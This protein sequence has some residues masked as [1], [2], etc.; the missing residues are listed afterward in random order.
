MKIAFGMIVFNGAYVL[1]ECLESVYPFASQILVAEGPVGYWQT[2][3]HTTSTDGTNGILKSFPDPDN[4]ITVVHGQYSEKDEQCSA[5]MEHLNSD[6]DYVWNLDSDE[7]FKPEDIE[8]IIKLLTDHR[9]TTAGFQ[10]CSFY[11]GFDKI[12]GG[13]EENAEFRRVCKVYPGSYWKTHRPPIMAHRDTRA[14]PENHM[15]FKWLWENHGIRMYHY[16]YVFPDQ[17]YNK[18]QYYKAAVSMDNCIDDYF[19]S[20]YLPWV[21]SDDDGKEHIENKYNGVHEFKPQFR[22]GCRT[23]P[24]DV[25]HPRIIKDGMEL[26]KQRFDSQLRKYT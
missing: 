14:W 20:V 23:K 4:K 16:S 9:F 19:D 22:G 13:F 18:V 12:L 6:T 7:I 5:Y 2:Q 25:E 11:G 17:V 10:S 1:K 26:L 3:G 24:F 15:G 21:R 8:T